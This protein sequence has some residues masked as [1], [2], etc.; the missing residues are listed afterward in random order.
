MT[1][2][3]RKETFETTTGKILGYFIF[4]KTL[5]TKMGNASSL[6]NAITKYRSYYKKMQ[7]STTN[8]CEKK[9]KQTLSSH[10]IACLDHIHPWILRHESI[11]DIVY[12]QPHQQ[13]W[14]AYLRTLQQLT[15]EDYITTFCFCSPNTK[16]F[17][18]GDAK[19]FREFMI[20]KV[21]LHYIKFHECSFVSCHGTMKRILSFLLLNQD[22]SFMMRK[23]RLPPTIV[24]IDNH[25]RKEPNH[26]SSCY[27]SPN[28]VPNFLKVIMQETLQSIFDKELLDML[29][30]STT[31]DDLK[32]VLNEFD[33]C[34]DTFHYGTTGRYSKTIDAILHQELPQPRR[35]TFS[36]K[37]FPSFC[38]PQTQ[39][40]VNELYV[41][42]A[43]GRPYLDSRCRPMPYSVA[44]LGEECWKH[45]WHYFGPLS[46]QCP[47]YHCQVCTYCS[48]FGSTMRLHKDNGYQSEDG[49]LAGTTAPSDTNSHI[50]GTDVMVVTLNDSMN[51]H[52][53]PPPSG[54]TH[55]AT[56]Q[57][58]MKEKMQSKGKVIELDEYS[59]Y[60]HS[61]HDD[62][63]YMHGLEFDSTTKKSQTNRTRFAFVFRWLCK[64]KMYRASE[65]D[66]AS[67]RYSV[68][69]RSAFDQI[70]KGFRI[71][72]NQWFEHLNYDDKSLANIERNL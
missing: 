32:T 54:S 33:H 5:P 26:V 53:V 10:Q 69:E 31:A 8:P 48:M 72:G 59:I 46:K 15:M 62:E 22:F 57:Q 41:Y 29:S 21:G 44:M 64:S 40:S 12:P 66:D 3:K 37:R 71:T 43:A 2:Q 19:T 55:R 67:N 4:N 61:A 45:C 25:Q 18:T 70:T 27:F 28:G 65:H 36:C 52:L 16:R 51:F 39:V 13:D 63:L 20:F 56:Q 23:V 38:I 47:P 14:L 50:F 6:Y 1:T 7:N 68:Y 11:I 60:I 9:Y 42:G 30:S 49:D 35:T 58:Y 34:F 17:V 24:T